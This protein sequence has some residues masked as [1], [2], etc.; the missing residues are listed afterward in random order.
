MSWAYILAGVCNLGVMIP[1]QSA[2]MCLWL[3]VM[4]NVDLGK[5]C[6]M[7]PSPQPGRGKRLC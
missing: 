3:H 1:S 4:Q 6:E 5:L 7:V 2:I